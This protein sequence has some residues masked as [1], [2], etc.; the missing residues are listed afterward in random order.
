MAPA[1]PVPE[2]YRVDVA[3][4]SLAV[5]DVP[6]DAQRTRVFELACAV[7][8]Q[9][10]GETS[11]AWHQLTVLDNGAKQWE[12]REPTR[13]P[14]EFDGLDVRYRREVPVGQALRIT[15]AVRCLGSRC[16]R[17]VIEADEQA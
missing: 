17:I 7:T 11:G 1:S 13:N 15:A 8:V 2:H 9:T 4:E 3:D 16:R 10:D 12:R 5:L 6:P 14:G